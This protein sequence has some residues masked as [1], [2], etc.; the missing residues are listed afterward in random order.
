MEIIKLIRIRNN[1]I[2]DPV[3]GVL[4]FV[5]LNNKKLNRNSPKQYIDDIIGVE[6]LIIGS[7]LK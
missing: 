2:K 4:A 3:H 1:A 6:Y 5:C 7:G